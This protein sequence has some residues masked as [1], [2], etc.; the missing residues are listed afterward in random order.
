[1]IQEKLKEL[2]E[3][4]GFVDV[5][6]HRFKWPI[7]AW[8]QDPKLREVGKWNQHRWYEGVEGYSLAFCTRVMGVSKILCFPFYLFIF[9]F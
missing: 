7:G 5:V 6:E 4:A 1:M 3:H 8:S 9:L 2:I